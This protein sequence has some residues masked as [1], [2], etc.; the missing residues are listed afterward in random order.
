MNNSIYNYHP[1]SQERTTHPVTTKTSHVF[2]KTGIT[3]VL[4]NTATIPSCYVM[5]KK[6][7]GVLHRD[8]KQEAIAE[9]FRSDKALTAIFFFERLKNLNTLIR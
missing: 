9:C 5:F 8:L 2:N 6:R 3:K 4:I 7:A 1:K